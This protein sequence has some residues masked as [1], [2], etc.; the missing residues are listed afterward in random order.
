[1]YKNKKIGVVVPAYNEEKLIKRVID[2]MPEFV[3]MIIVVDD[4]SKDR[5]SEIVE[6]CIKQMDRKIILVRHDENQGVGAAIVSG[7]KKAIE[8]E[9]DAV[10]VMAGDAQMN[11]D[12]LVFLVDPIVEDKADYVK[13]NRFAYGEAW[14]RI[15]KVRYLGN[16]LLSLMTKIASGYWHI[17]DSQTGYTVISLNMLKSLDLDAI[18]KR[19]GYPNDILVRLN[20]EN[21]RVMDIPIKPIYNIGEKSGIKIWKIIPLLSF[22]LTKL[23][24]IRLFQ[25][26]VIRDFHP[27]VF[28]YLSGFL[29]FPAGLVLGSLF[30]YKF[31]G[32]YISIASIVISV[33]MLIL[34]LQFVLFAMWFDMDYNRDLCI[35]YRKLTN[36]RVNKDIM[37]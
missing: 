14:K 3:D 26:Y 4:V 5:T 13:G 24:F 12:E 29:M 35:F 31:I 9:L 25:K 15:P 32:G 2:T 34:S 36:Y 20:I 23:F 1:M 10:G 19:Y 6:N 11:P 18:Y 33:F 16:A 37:R 28:F 30:V 8:M 21:A 27:L 17:A 22:L 7:Y